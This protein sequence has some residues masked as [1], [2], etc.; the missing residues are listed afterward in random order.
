MKQIVSS[1]QKILA[2]SSKFIY[3]SLGDSPELK[4][5]NIIINLVKLIIMGIIAR[6]FE[7]G[8][9]FFYKFVN[10]I[11]NIFIMLVTYRNV[12]FL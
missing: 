5:L 10:K 1:S 4:N 3:D 2:N 11:I 8:K 9:V 12:L 7:Q 6:I